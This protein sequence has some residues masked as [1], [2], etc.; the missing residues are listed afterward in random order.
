MK[1]NNLI[2]V[3]INCRNSQKYI[4]E[5]IDSVINQTYK[6]FEIIIVNNNST[7]NTKNIIFSY[8]D[9]RIK[10]FELNKS[11]SLGAARNIALKE[12]SGEF[13]AFIDSDDI[14]DKSK[15]E[16]TLKEF[17][18]NIGLVY[19]DVVY[20]NSE[21]SFNLY[22]GRKA[23]EGNCFSSLL[24][25]YNLCISSC[26]IS[27][28]Y[29]NQFLFDENLNVCEDLDF[30]LKISYKSKLKYVPKTLVKYRIHGS[31][32]SITNQHMFYEEF[33]IVLKNL[34]QKFNIENKLI[35]KME[36]INYINYAKFFWKNRKIKESFT[37]LKKIKTL[38]FK[39]SVYKLIILVPYR[40][41]NKIYRI[42]SPVKIE[43]TN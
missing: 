18:N 28:K 21:K 32:L 5:T 23:Y 33:K 11:I 24:T 2:S 35:I 29:M 38:H 3:I 40:F 30:F 41:V 39:A 14:W 8:S 12:S 36:D 10:Y 37:E 16:Q 22:K 9:Q 19:S 25:D 1:K 6:N 31:N 27:R 15:I 20:F 42:I 13:I 4:K 7:D 43:L 26:V 34:Q 17:Q